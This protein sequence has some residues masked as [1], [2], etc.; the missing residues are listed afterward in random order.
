MGFLSS[1]GSVLNNLTGATSAGAQSQRYAIASA[2]LN[3]AYQKEFAQH[4]HQWEVEDLQKAGLNPILSAGGSGTSA[5]GGGVASATEQSAGISPIDAI[6]AGVSAYSG[7]QNAKQMRAQATNLDAETLLTKAKTQS[8]LLDLAIKSKASPNII[9]KYK[10]D[11]E[12][13]AEQ[14]NAIQTGV[15][16]KILG[17][18]YGKKLNKQINQEKQ[19]RDKGKDTVKNSK[20]AKILERVIEL[21]LE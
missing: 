6:A 1:V 18:A 5:S 12:Y 9:E 7:I 3:N 8:E 17:T 2:Q 14:I 11:L 20:P 15:G 19:Q 4:G 10:K 21:M 16:S 13:T